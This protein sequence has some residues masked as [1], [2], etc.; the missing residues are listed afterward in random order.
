MFRLIQI[1]PISDLIIVYDVGDRVEIDGNTYTIK[2][3]RLLSTIFIDSRGC[4]VQAPNV[5]L[6]G[7]VSTFSS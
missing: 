4:Q 5:V 2:E 3:I 7:K 1:Y 6:N